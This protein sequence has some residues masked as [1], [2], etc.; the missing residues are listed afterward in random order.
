ME[1]L[2]YLDAKELYDQFHHD[3]PWDSEHNKPLVEKMPEAF[4]DP[5]VGDLDGKTVFVVPTGKETM[6]FDDNG[7]TAKQI[8]DGLDWTIS[9]VEADASTRSLGPSPTISR[10]TRKLTAGLARGRGCDHGGSG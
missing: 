2:P 5:R 7:T 9:I 3:E 8:S 6:Y 4:Y 10:L 1:L